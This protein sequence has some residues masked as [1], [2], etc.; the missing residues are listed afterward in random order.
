M[1]NEQRP[2]RFCSWQGCHLRLDGKSPKA[3]YCS[4]ACKMKAYR[5]R[6]DPMNQPTQRWEAPS[7]VLCE[8]VS[9]GYRCVF[10]DGHTVVVPGT[11]AGNAMARA[12]WGRAK[13]VDA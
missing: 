6:N 2:L 3:K 7:V 1:R 4:D 12:R 10:E 9:N 13:R 8:P 5:W 11:G